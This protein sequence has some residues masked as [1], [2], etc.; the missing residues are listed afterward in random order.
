MNPWNPY[1]VQTSVGGVDVYGGT[2]D[3]SVPKVMATAPVTVNN[4]VC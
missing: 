3:L 4:N 1:S 2:H